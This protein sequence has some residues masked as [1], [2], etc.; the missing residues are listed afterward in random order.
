M[1]ERHL[2]LNSNRL[3][4]FEDARL[5]IVTYVEAKF[6][7]RIRDSK[8]S[9]TG[10]CG[11]S[12]PVDVDAVNSLSSGKGEGSS[13][14]RD[15]GFK[16]LWSIF[17]TRLQ[18]TQR[19][20]QAIVSQ[21]QTEQVMVPRVRTKERVK[22]TRE[23]PKEGPKEPKDRS[24]VP[25]AHTRVKHRTLVCQALKTRNR[26]QA[27]KLQNLHTSVP[28]TILGFMMAGVMMTG[29]VEQEMQDSF[30]LPVLYS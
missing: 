24:K 13:T 25:N 17:P 18:C 7:L 27:R 15:G 26:R 6:G 30:G 20:W 21:G 2:M 14:P 29:K 4:T 12:D 23:N 9:D 10:S 3:R 16:V 1:P 8:P 22:R 5:E 19:H 28:L 11:H